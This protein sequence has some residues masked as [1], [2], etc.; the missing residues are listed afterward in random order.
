VLPDGNVKKINERSFLT[1]LFYLNSVPQESGG[2]T[3]FYSPEVFRNG[4]SGTEKENDY[5]QMSI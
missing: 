4:H 2:A 5:I 3:N 1:V